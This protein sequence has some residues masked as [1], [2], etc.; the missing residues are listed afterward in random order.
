[1]EA[2][3]LAVTYP[4]TLWAARHWFRERNPAL[5]RKLSGL[6]DEIKREIGIKARLVA[7]LAGW[8][9]CSMLRQ[10]E[11]RLRAGWTYEPPTFYE[12]NAPML[13][14][15]PQWTFPVMPIKWVAACRQEA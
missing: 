10:E 7:P 5:A 2:R 4:A 9:V 3:V 11:K 12:A 6:L 14:G 13:R 1:M 15:R 8:I